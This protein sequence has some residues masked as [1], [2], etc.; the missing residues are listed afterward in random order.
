MHRISHLLFAFIVIQVLTVGPLLAV[1][2]TLSHQGRLLNADGTPAG[3]AYDVSY[4]LYDAESGGN[5]LWQ[6]TQLTEVD[7]GYFSVVLG[8]S[9]P[10]DFSSFDH[11][12]DSIWLEIQVGGDSPISPRT[13]LTAAPLA[14]IATALEGDIETDP[15]L[16]RLDASKSVPGKIVFIDSTGDTTV[17]IDGKGGDGGPADTSVVIKRG[18]VYF[19][20]PNGVVYASYAAGE[21]MI[22]DSTGD[23]TFYVDGNGDGG[24]ADTQ[25]IIKRGRIN[26]KQIGGPYRA[27][28][29]AGNLMLADSTGDTTV[30]VDGNR[31]VARGG[32]VLQVETKYTDGLGQNLEDQ[33]HVEGGLLQILRRLD[34]GA[35]NFE[36]HGGVVATP[37]GISFVDTTGDTTMQLRCKKGDEVKLVG[38]G[39]FTKPDKTNSDTA[40]VIDSSGTARFAGEMTVGTLERLATLT[41]DGDICATGTIGACSDARYKTRV[42]PIAGALDKVLAMRGVNY[43]WRQSEFAN[44]KFESGNQ[45]GVIAQEIMEIAPEVVTQN[46]NGYYSVDYGKL[47]PLLIEAIRSQQSMIQNQNT[48]LESMKQEL[49]ELKQVVHQLAASK[50]KSGNSNYAASAETQS[51]DH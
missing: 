9:T 25:V 5:I 46:N 38:F 27:S 22:A 19:V 48:E 21:M 37:T 1:P 10:L 30:T 2:L 11:R 36:P 13:Q 43:E 50:D 8:K 17:Q 23:T 14:A 34:D 15:G 29:G 6:E 12:P 28:M 41:V 39:T 31:G 26:W 32:G 42:T 47:T 35:G 18:I 16:V 45:V 20:R 51:I 40:F 44:M 3:G 24:P 33:S 7:S 4:R 49:A